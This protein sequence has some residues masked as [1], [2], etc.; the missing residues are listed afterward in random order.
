MYR[1]SDVY[2]ETNRDRHHHKNNHRQRD[3]WAAY[4]EANFY[5]DSPPPNMTDTETEIEDQIDS[6]AEESWNQAISKANDRHHRRRE[7]KRK[8]IKISKPVAVAATTTD[9]YQ[10]DVPTDDTNRSI[11]INMDDIGDVE[12]MINKLKEVRRYHRLNKE[13]QVKSFLGLSKNTL[14]V[15]EVCNLLLFATASILFVFVVDMILKSTVGLT[16]CRL[17]KRADAPVANSLTLP[18][19]SSSATTL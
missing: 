19:A 5:T 7:K 13:D 11:T 9:N 16:K 6:A 15:R 2:P 8:S 10:E 18:T 4:E 12:Q 17:I 1:V 3:K 14:K